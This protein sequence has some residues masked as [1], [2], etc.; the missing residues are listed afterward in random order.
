MQSISFKSV[1][2]PVRWG[3]IGCGDVCEVKSGPAF[4]KSEGSSLVAVMRRNASKAE[5]FARRH[6]VARW[7]TDAGQ[8]IADPEVDAVYIAT[9][10]STHAVYAISAMRSGKPVYVEKPMAA[11]YIECE[12][13][14]RVSDETGMLLFVA[15][16]RRSLP[17]FIKVKEI[18]D[19]GEIGEII[20]V[21]IRFHSPANPLD[22]DLQNQPWRVQPAIAGA[23]YF[24]D[25]ACHTLDILDFLLGKI[26]GACG[27]ATNRAGLY[28]AEDTVAA[29]FRFASGAV[30]CGEW[31]YAAPA[32]ASC[33]E[34]EITGS[35]GRVRFATFSFM[36]ILVQTL[37]SQA[38]YNFPRPEHIQ[39]PMVETVVGQL[40]GHGKSPS[41]GISAAR[42]NWVMDKILNAQDT[43]KTKET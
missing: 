34:I 18:L 28:A 32:V 13:M 37:H 17:Y 3:I 38:E 24:Y 36:P 9:P 31:A 30:G 11:S 22:G 8:L 19:S 40:C 21:S 10:P 29:S 23:G 12:E 39:Q 26:T 41:D 4:Y 42:T 35:A 6:H 27:Q 5:D 43:I 14:N 20:G 2:A 25:M 15:Y 7:Y 33:D 16:Y 1:A